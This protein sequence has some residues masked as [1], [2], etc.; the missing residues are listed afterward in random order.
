MSMYQIEGHHKHHCT[1]LIEVPFSKLGLNEDQSFYLFIFFFEE[2]VNWNLP[3]Q[4]NANVL[5]GCSGC[6]FVVGNYFSVSLYGCYI[7][8]IIY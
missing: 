4:N 3:M 2:N 1:I 5:W 7:A 8:N 6:F